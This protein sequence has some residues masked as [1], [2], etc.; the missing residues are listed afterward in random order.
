[1]NRIYKTEKLNKECWSNLSDKERGQLLDLII[2]N[3]FTSYLEVG[4]MRG[5][6]LINMTNLLKLNNK[7]CE[8]VGYDCFELLQDCKPK[9]N[10]HTSGFPKKETVEKNVNTLH[11]CNVE[12]IMGLSENINSIFKDRKFDLIFHDA[13]H[14]YKG[15]YSDLKIL[16]KILNKN[17]YICLHDANKCKAFRVHEAIEDICEEGLYERAGMHGTI[18]T[19]KPTW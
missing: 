1:M 9:H 17:G 18:A 15:V 2:D 3:N 14:S 4:V 11:G 19:L 12:L 10:T 5:G 6:N 16:K 8:I 13:D 7:K